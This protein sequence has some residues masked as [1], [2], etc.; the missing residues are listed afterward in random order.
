MKIFGAGLSRTGTLS[1]SRAVGML[2][3][4]S[5]HWA[6]SFD[7]LAFDNGQ[8]SIRFSEVDRYDALFDIPVAHYFKELDAHYPEA[9]FIL[10]VRERSSWLRSCERFLRPTP[11]QLAKLEDPKRAQI[12]IEV[13]GVTL[14]DRERFEQAYE[15][16]VQSVMEHF[17]GRPDDLLVMN[18]CQGDGWPELCR[19]LRKPIPGAPFPRT[20][21]TDYEAV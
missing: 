16:H 3:F 6:A 19:F 18:I 9:R 15:R 10:T 2:G 5:R 13:Y 8:L 21:V 1:L 7:T 17:A 11:E 20:H 4:H 12:R 14:F